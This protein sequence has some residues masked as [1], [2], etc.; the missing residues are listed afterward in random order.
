MQSIRKDHYRPGNSQI[1]TTSALCLILLSSV[2]TADDYVEFATN[3]PAGTK[4]VVDVRMLRPTQFAVGM[5]EVHMRVEKLKAKDLKA[6]LNRYLLKKIM[7]IVIGPGGIP[8]VLDHHHL[9]RVLLEAGCRTTLYAEVRENC[10]QLTE[11]EFWKMLK[12]KNWVFLYDEVGRG[13]LDTAQLP[14]TIG[15]LRD[16]PYRSVSWVVREGGGYLETDT[17]YAEFQ[18]ANFF[19]TKIPLE[20][21]RTNFEGA[22]DKAMTLTSSKEAEKLPGYRK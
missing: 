4:C 22:V 6:A 11:S 10:S 1:L 3:L 8:Y 2:V 12:K 5:K 18:W 14:K 17:P 21:V 19:R 15:E 9:A 13:P 16:D 7:P 20:M